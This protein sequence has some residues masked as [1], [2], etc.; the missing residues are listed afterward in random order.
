MKQNKEQL[1]L[2]IW[3]SFPTTGRLWLFNPDVTCA[4][5]MAG[6][7]TMP[8]CTLFLVAG[9]DSQYSVPFPF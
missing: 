2:S 6:P 9:L 4:G 3:A 5:C 1:V 8:D 7:V